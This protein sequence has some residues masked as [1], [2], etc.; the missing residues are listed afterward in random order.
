[1][2]GS[3]HGGHG[4]VDRRFVLGALVVVASLVLAEVAF[5]VVREATS[6]EPTTLEKVQICLTERSRP[7]E[8]VPDDPIASSAKRGALRTDVEGNRVTVA[9]GSSENDAERVYR[10]Y[11]AVAP[12]DVVQT[13]L[14]LSRKVVFFWEMPPTS[15]QRDFMHLCTLDAQE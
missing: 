12:D 3:E 10:A 7:F 8:P 6:N 2:S 9:L 14:E 11:V 13:N 5:G 15:S 1:V 4:Q